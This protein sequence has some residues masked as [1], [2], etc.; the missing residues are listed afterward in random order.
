MVTCTHRFADAMRPR[1]EL[2]LRARRTELRVVY[3][4]T[5]TLCPPALFERRP[6]VHQRRTLALV[7]RAD[8][9]V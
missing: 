7:Q 5:H 3:R 2:L 6:V 8:P 9:A 1:Q 4:T